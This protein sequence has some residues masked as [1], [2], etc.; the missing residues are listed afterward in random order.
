V[1][2]ERSKSSTVV[3]QVLIRFELRPI[4]CGMKAFR[5]FRYQPNCWPIIGVGCLVLCIT[6]GCSRSE[7]SARQYIDQSERQWAESVATN[8]SSVVERILADDF[9]WVY[10]DGRKLNKAQAVTDARNGPGPFV[11]NHPESISIRF[12]GNV[13]VAQ[14]SESWVQKHNGA[15]VH[16]RFVW[17]DTWVKRNGK[18]QI[19]AAEDLIPPTN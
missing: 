17:T 13:A 1:G 11:S 3:N 15:E 6:A 4:V 10:P 8:D 2:V 9:V 5:S 7:D 19:V 14:G 18:W 16:G 12:F